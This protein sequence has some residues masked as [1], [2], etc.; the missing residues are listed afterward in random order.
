MSGGD[1]IRNHP[2]REELVEKGNGALF[3]GVPVADL[4]REGLL[5][6][7]GKLGEE[8]ERERETRRKDWAAVK[9]LRYL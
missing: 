2:R 7:I 5:M 9:S 3:Y 4:D 6:L 8:K 1:R